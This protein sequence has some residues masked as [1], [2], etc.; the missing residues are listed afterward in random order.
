MTIPEVAEALAAVPE[1]VEYWIRKLGIEVVEDWADRRAIRIADA[2]R[3]VMEQRTA[4]EQHSDKWASFKLW[5]AAKREAAAAKRAEE[6]QKEQAR[7]A[8][9]RDER[10]RKA[11]EDLAIQRQRDA[12]AAE[13]GR[14]TSGLTFADFE[15]TL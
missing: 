5:L 8:K 13:A 11:E 9:I 12:E 1:T 4:A 14:A 10:R 15:K 2:R 3:V 7:L 6:W